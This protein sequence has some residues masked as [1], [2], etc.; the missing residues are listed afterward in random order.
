MH[1]V[2][3]IKLPG[4]LWLDG[5][6]H[7]D[8]ELH[9]LTGDD[10][11]FLLETGA[12]L[13]PAQRTTSLLS[14]CLT[15][16]G[17]LKQV[18]TDTVRSLTVGD[19]EALLLNLRRMT[20]GDRLQCVLTCPNPDCG[21][22]MDLELKVSDLLLPPYV[23]HQA[24]YDTTLLENG[25]RYTVRFH[26]PDGACQEEA[27]LLARTD[28][29][30][31]ASLLLH[32]CIEFI[33]SEEGRSVD[34]LPMGAPSQLSARMQ[35]LD[36]QAELMLN[37]TCPAC[38][39]NFSTIFDTCTYFFQELTSRVKHLYREIHLLAFHYHWSEAEIMGMTSKKRRLYLDLLTEALAE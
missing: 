36:P 31:A 14:R 20:L 9:P 39:Y 21:E 34:H 3:N 37:A 1:T 24:L 6:C 26:L 15:R 2:T 23:G 27:A 30:A 25:D 12:A 16:L 28:P 17:S 22:K 33:G 32:R 4:G 13:L 29:Q 38:S 18:T 8:A 19:R 7:R 10:E 35:E 5:T 11:V